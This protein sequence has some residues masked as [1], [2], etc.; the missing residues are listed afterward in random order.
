[1]GLCPRLT[2][3][4]ASEPRRERISGAGHVQYCFCLRLGA[5]D[6]EVTVRIVE[7]PHPA[8]AHRDDHSICL[9]RAVQVII[10]ASGNSL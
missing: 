4:F 2:E 10:G 5:N 9:D 3:Q 1:V 8:A 6:F 7:E